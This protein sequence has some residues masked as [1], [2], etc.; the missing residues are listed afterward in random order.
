MCL[1][2]IFNEAGFGR[3]KQ[4]IGSEGRLAPRDIPDVSDPS[5]GFPKKTRPVCRRKLKADVHPCA[6]PLEKQTPVA[7]PVASSVT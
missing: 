3:R 7:V 6:S 2:C 4:Y 1:G 5:R